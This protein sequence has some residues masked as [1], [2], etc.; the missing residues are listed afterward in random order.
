[1]KVGGL[2]EVSFYRYCVMF[3]PSLSTLARTAAIGGFVVIGSSFY[4]KS[5]IQQGIKQSEYFK[6]SLRILRSHR[7]IAYLLGE[8]I[9][10]GNLD[11][12]DNVNNFCT[13]KEAQFQKM[14]KKIHTESSASSDAIG[15]SLEN[16][17]PI[18]GAQLMKSQDEET[19]NVLG[20]SQN[21]TSSEYKVALETE[22][23]ESSE[24]NT[25]S[26]AELRRYFQGALSQLLQ[27]DPILADLH[28]QVTLEESRKG[29]KNKISWRYIWKTYWLC[30]NGEKLTDDNT[31]LLEFGI[32]NKSTLTFVKKYRERQQFGKRNG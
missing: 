2:P 5:R 22:E 25:L 4:F 24:L 28:P 12:G 27:D 10:D 3:L 8:P 29:A 26:H 13:G 14:E 19:E 20:N 9:R 21:I 11:L 23:T 31:R 7:G 32:R 15:G 18:C 30:Y 17:L 6:E 1:M 16:S